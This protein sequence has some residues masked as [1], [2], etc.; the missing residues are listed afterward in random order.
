MVG[1]SE[2]NESL[3][4]WNLL[5]GEGCLGL[6]KDLNIRELLGIDFRAGF[7]NAFNHTNLGIALASLNS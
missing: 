1:A 2:L 5:A 3:K 7:F 4:F 6:L